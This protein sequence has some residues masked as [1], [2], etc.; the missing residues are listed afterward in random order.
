MS[1]FGDS[2]AS[3]W[4]TEL[5]W[6]GMSGR[7]AVPAAGNG[8]Q[9]S[10]SRRR[11]PRFK[12]SQAS[13]NLRGFLATSPGMDGAVYRG[14]KDFWGLHTGLLRKERVH[15]KPAFARFKRAVASCERG[16]RRHEP[17]RT[18]LRATEEENRAR[19]SGCLAEAAAV[20]CS[21]SHQ[22]R[23]VHDAGRGPARGDARRRHRAHRGHAAG[24][25][26]RGFESCAPTSTTGSLR[27]REFDTVHANRSSSTSRHSD[28]VPARGPARA[29]A[30]RPRVDLDQQPVVVHNVGALA[31]ATSR[32]P[33]T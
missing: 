26:A 24:A 3:L 25:R 18:A 10:G 5:G 14:G 2:G 19:S 4:V 20:R 1:R 32:C 17:P 31:L 12:S 23:R 13:L 29:E 15:G 22:Y 6:V 16:L 9:S 33:P 28:R 30:R 27:R 7:V 21:T 8:G 11:S